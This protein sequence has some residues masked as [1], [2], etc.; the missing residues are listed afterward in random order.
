M[1]TFFDKITASE[2]ETL[3]WLNANPMS[4]PS[5][6]FFDDPSVDGRILRLEQISLVCHVGDGEYIIS[7]LGK[8][9]LVEH[10]KNRK[11]KQKLKAIEW[12]KFIIPTVLSIA[13]FIKSFFY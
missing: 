3:I 7:E 9:A 8:S 11:Y 2:Y 13:A 12:I 4:L 5:D 1:G 6:R 10:Q